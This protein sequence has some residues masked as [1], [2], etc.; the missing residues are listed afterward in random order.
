M[1]EYKFRG[2]RVDTK[3]WVYGYLVKRETHNKIQINGSCD[4]FKEFNFDEFKE[5]N[6][7]EYD[8]DGEIVLYEHWY[9]YNEDDDRTLEQNFIEIIPE[10]VGQ[11]NERKD[12]NNKEIYEGD[13]IKESKYRDFNCSDLRDYYI[14]VINDISDLDFGILNEDYENSYDLEILGNIHDATP[15]QLKEWGIEKWYYQYY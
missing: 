12:K 5:F 1:R 13:I 10:T 11:Y 15:E 6:L 4:E 8:I 2:Q 9:I 7:I 14:E 3:E